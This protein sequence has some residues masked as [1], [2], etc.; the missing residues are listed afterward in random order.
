MDAPERPPSNRLGDADALLPLLRAV[1]RGG[2][3]A[4]VSLLE[5][6]APDAPRVGGAGPPASEVVRFRHDHSLAFS[7]SE[8]SRVAV[9]PRPEDAFAAAE[10]ISQVDVTATFL[11]LTGS[12]SPMP[13]H[14][15]EE[16]AQEHGELTVRADFVDIFHHRLYSL[17]YR[18][19]VKFDYPR[20]YL[21]DGSDPWS[22]RILALTGLE[23]AAH[24]TLPTW[25]RLRL[26]PLLATRVRSAEVLER[27]L[28][29]VL[30]DEL[31]GARVTIEQFVGAWVELDPKQRI[32]LGRQ[33]SRLG[34]DTVLGNQ[35]YDR[36]GKFRIT[37]APLTQQT[38]ERLLPGRDLLPVVVDVVELVVADSLSFELE[39][40]L[41]QAH[42]PPLRL[43]AVAGARLGQTA[44]LGG[45]D[46]AGRRVRFDV[47]S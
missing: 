26:A 24:S 7:A 14:L 10:T 12:V 30:A 11:G 47:G 42:V 8:V 21:V 36:G 16:V 41:G 28:E 9:A 18:L 17:L 1:G 40:V 13:G 5:R 33:H 2:F 3:V 20:E 44:W 45:S 19:V 39:L 35:M 22:Q 37:M 15:A 6:L 31:D 4:L 34:R 43:S 25:R 46:V 32:R 27:V 29:D 23:E 38:Y